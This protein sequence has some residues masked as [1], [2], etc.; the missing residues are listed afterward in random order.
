MTKSKIGQV[1]SYIVI[2]LV[3]VAVIGVFAYFTNGFTSDFKTFYVSVNG[4]DVMASGNGYVV[5]PSEPLK[6]DVKYTFAFNKNETK[7]Y[8]VKSFR[9]R[10]TKISTSPLTAKR[11]SLATKKT[12]QAVL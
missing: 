1:V 8:S 6:V 11:I 10:R 9:T 7:G 4:K 5:T 2:L 3:I 12:L